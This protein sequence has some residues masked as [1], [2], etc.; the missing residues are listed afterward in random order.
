MASLPKPRGPPS[1]VVAIPAFGWML[2]DPKG[3]LALGFGLIGLAGFGVDYPQDDASILFAQPPQGFGRIFT[4]YR[5]TKIPVAFAYQVTPKLA[6]GASL[7]VYMGEFA[8]SPLPYKVFDLDQS[9]N[10]F[11]PEAGRLSRS[12]AIVPGTRIVVVNIDTGV[13][14]E[15]GP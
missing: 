11:Y 15:T 5:E 3:K 9:G 1:Q 14:R 4:D 8:V 13:S 10:R 12:W 2:R 7:N 6:L